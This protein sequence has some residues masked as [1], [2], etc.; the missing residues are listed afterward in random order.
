M[1]ALSMSDIA[2]VAGQLGQDQTKD[3]PTNES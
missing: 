3:F 2:P 1:P